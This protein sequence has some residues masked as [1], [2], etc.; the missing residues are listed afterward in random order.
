MRADRPLCS[1]RV[2]TFSPSSAIRVP[3][4]SS[5]SSAPQSATTVAVAPGSKRYSVPP[6]TRSSRP[7]SSATA[8][9]TSVG[10]EPRATTVATR[11]SAACSPARRSISA[12]ACAF[13]IAVPTSSVKAA[14][15]DSAS[16]WSGA[17]SFAEA[18]ITPHSRWSTTIGA[19]TEED[20]PR[21]R[22]R[23]AT[24]PVARS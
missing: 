11:R 21:P 13:E 16:T 4:G 15:R 19:P 17:S 14:I 18:I 10:E 6:S 24:S 5:A 7:T 22:M 2:A 3:T 9:K 23:V 1:T 12:R 20:S 8:A